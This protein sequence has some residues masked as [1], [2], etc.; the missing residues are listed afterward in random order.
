[1]DDNHFI[2]HIEDPGSNRPLTL[3]CDSPLSHSSCCFTSW[4]VWQSFTYCSLHVATTNVTWLL[5]SLTS[6]TTYLEK[7]SSN[8]TSVALSSDINST[9]LSSTTWVRIIAA[10]WSG[11][12]SAAMFSSFSLRLLNCCFNLLLSWSFY[13]HSMGDSTFSACFNLSC[14]RC[15]SS[16]CDWTLTLSRSFDRFVQVWTTSASSV[17]YCGTA[18]FISSTTHCTLTHL[19]S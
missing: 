15:T 14:C 17:S 4:T 12:S 6:S 2:F 19:S 11:S 18:D 16:I 13:I 10:S 3:T 5:C 9:F 7:G 8:L 1:M